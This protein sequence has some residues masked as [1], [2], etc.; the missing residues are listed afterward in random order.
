MEKKYKN[1][2]AELNELIVQLY[3]KI[4]DYEKAFKITGS[5]SIFQ[6]LPD[7]TVEDN[8]SKLFI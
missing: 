4:Q 8:V 2:I 3:K 6:T 5:S 7:A 1:K